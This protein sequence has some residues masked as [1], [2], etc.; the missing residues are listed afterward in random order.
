MEFE[1]TEENKFIYTDIH[2]E[3]VS[4]T[5]LDRYHYSKQYKIPVLNGKRYWMEKE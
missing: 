1:D 3:Y 4:M 2:K 5:A